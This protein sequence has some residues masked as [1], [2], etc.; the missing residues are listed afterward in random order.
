[1]HQKQAFRT[2]LHFIVL[3]K[4]YGER[5]ERTDTGSASEVIGVTHVAMAAER[6][7]A[8]DALAVLT[9]VRHHLTLVDVCKTQ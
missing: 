4:G 3:N 5:G 9:Q 7:D 8:V 2:V 1:M 6:A